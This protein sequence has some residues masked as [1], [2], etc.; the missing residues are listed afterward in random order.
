[1]RFPLLATGTPLRVTITW[2]TPL[3]PPVTSNKEPARYAPALQAIE[4]RGS[5]GLPIGTVETGTRIPG[6]SV[7]C[8]LH[9]VVHDGH[10]GLARR[11]RHRRS[12]L[13]AINIRPGGEPC[14]GAEKSRADS[15]PPTAIRVIQLSAR[16]MTWVMKRLLPASWTM[17]TMGW[18]EELTTAEPRNRSPGSSGSSRSGGLYTTQ[19]NPAG[20]LLRHPGGLVSE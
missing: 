17:P 15:P 14:I 12:F 18:L 7:V 6:R 20:R 3:Q 2:L 13:D 5:R 1:M 4:G 16:A 19:W 9:R 8:V 10:D 11:R